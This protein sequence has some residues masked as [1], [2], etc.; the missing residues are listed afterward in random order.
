MS[1]SRDYLT[2]T[3]LRKICVQLG[4][5][6]EGLKSELV[7]RIV[8]FNEIHRTVP[9]SSDVSQI[10]YSR[11]RISPILNLE[12]DDSLSLHTV[13]LSEPPILSEQSTQT[14]NE[15]PIDDRKG[16]IVCCNSP[17]RSPDRMLVIILLVVCFIG[18]CITIF[19][20]FGVIEKIE[21]PVKRSWFWN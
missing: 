20:S 19:N 18:A 15:S 14:M 17:F 6:A 4:L 11:T 3:E 10:R 21:V 9:S 16:P 12:Q 2:I 5:S 7:E 1:D 13:D 8:N